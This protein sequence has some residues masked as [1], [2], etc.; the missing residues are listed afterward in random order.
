MISWTAGLI[1]PLNYQPAAQARS[2]L[3]SG[4]LGTLQ[5]G[6]NYVLGGRCIEKRETVKTTERDEVKSFCFLEPF[7]TVRHGI[8]IVRP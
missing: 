6:L 5:Y 7:Q 3:I 8:I 2:S 4:E 1:W